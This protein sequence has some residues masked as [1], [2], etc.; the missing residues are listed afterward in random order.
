MSPFASAQFVRDVTI[1]DDTELPGGT[2]FVKTWLL[3]NNGDVPWGRATRS[4]TSA[5]CP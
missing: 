2:P 5:A 4:T 3:E 1:P